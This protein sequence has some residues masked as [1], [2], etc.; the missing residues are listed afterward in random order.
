L[1]IK[2]PSAGLSPPAFSLF[3]KEQVF[4]LLATYPFIFL[5]ATCTFFLFLFWQLTPLSSFGQL[6][7]SFFE[8]KGSRV[9][10]C[11]GRKPNQLT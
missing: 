2:T 7:L 3:L 5:W 6:A 4:S 8:R 9:R 10:T 11:A 1:K